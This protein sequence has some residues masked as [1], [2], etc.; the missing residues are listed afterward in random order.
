MS[1]IPADS[2]ASITP[3]TREE[4]LRLL[5]ETVPELRVP[6]EPRSFSAVQMFI[7]QALCAEDKS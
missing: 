4:M 5:Q 3:Q 6:H 1:K 7:V 2:M